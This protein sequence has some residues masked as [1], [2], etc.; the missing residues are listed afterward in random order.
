MN[1][2]DLYVI[3]NL[4][5]YNADNLLMFNARYGVYPG[6]ENVRLF[7]Y[8]GILDWTLIEMMNEM[9]L[10][11]DTAQQYE[12][13]RAVQDYLAELCVE[14]P[15]YSEN[16]ITFYSDQKWDGWIEAEGLSIW[17]SYSTRYLRRG[18]A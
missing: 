12:R 6:T 17:N 14:I 5:T 3:I 9:E 16:T 18:E 13:C 2:A 1:Q 4:V 7:N 15:L 10:T 8:S 11:S